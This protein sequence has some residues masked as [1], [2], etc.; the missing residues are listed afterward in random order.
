MNKG[1][2]LTSIAASAAILLGA[3]T[4][5]AMAVGMGMSYTPAPTP[6]PQPIAPTTGVKPAP[7]TTA[8]RPEIGKP[9]QEAIDLAKKNDFTNALAKIKEA[10]AVSDKNPYEEY[11]VGKLLGQILAHLHDDAGAA[12]ALDRA[13]A[14]NGAPK[15][16]LAQTL[17][18][19]MGLNI[20]IKN[21]AKAISAGE[22]LQ[23]LGPI[24]PTAAGDLALA[25]YFKGDYKNALQQGQTALELQSANG[26]TP[27]V[28]TLEIIMNS[29]IK[30]ND[31]AG[32]KKTLAMLCARPSPPSELKCSPPGK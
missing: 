25:Y 13:V 24:D 18:L 12:A 2:L 29:Q 21:Y 6:Q 16:E 15:E 10:D 7:S 27:N 1:R 4:T 3:A 28:Q 22:Q 8:A 30:T 23:R 26:G 11:L 5:S 20:N 17:T 9:A 14:S 19:D 32:A 31:R